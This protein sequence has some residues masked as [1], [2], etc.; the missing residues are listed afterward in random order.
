MSASLHLNL[1]K[2][3]ERRSPNPVRL[4][5]LCPILAG[6]LAVASLLW[7][8]L[9]AFRAHAQTTIR[10]NLKAGIQEL[11]AAYT[12]AIALRAQEKEISAIARQLRL[13]ESSRIRFGEA[14]CKLPEDVPENVQLTEMSI[15]KPPPPAVDPM[16]PALGPT[17]KLERVTLRLAGRTAGEKASAAVDTLLA[18]LRRPGYTNLVQTADIPKGAFRQDTT[19]RNTG[20]RDALLFEITCGCVPRRFE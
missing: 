17:N 3:E 10:D 12:Q 20:S 2:E 4:R 14:L 6:G 9:L 15:P 13:Y 7:W 19:S 8:S 16:Q 18:A 11:N 5:V 1:L